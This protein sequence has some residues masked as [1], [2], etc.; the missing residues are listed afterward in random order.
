LRGR[1]GKLAWQIRLFRAGLWLPLL[2][3]AVFVASARVSAQGADKFVI[4]GEATKKALSKSEISGATAAKIAQVCED[5]A[6]QHNIAVSIFILSPAGSIVH[7]HR[8]DGQ[9]PTAIDTA[10]YKAQSALYS[11]TST[12]E[13]ANRTADNLGAQ[14]RYYTR[15][16][17]FPVSGGM[18]IIVDNQL[19]GA[20]GVG[21]S[22]MDEE[23]AYAALTAVIGTQPPL[24]PKLP[25]T[26]PAQAPR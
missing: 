25:A 11:R 17:Q 24:A 12:H 7:A 2:S 1:E 21:G 9:S 13:L 18:P 3:A 15:L 5:F 8:M 4:T 26:L 10:L 20:I 22:N 16:N 6:T 14:L 19:I 23:C